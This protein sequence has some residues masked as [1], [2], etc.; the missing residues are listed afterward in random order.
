MREKAIFLQSPTRE[1]SFLDSFGIFIFW[2]TKNHRDLHWEFN[3][4]QDISHRTGDYRKS[5]LFV[6]DLNFGAGFRNKEICSVLLCCGFEIIEG[7]K[8]QSIGQ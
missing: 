3:I 2:A 8:F 1:D 4:N 6:I 7:G 5:Q